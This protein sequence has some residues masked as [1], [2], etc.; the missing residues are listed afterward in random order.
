MEGVRE[1]ERREGRK[2]CRMGRMREWERHR[3]M[4]V[5]GVGR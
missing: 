2:E 5:F 3:G 1:T 4:E